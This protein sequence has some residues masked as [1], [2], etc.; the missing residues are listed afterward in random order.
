MN[1]EQNKMGIHHVGED[2]IYYAGDRVITRSSNKAMQQTYKIDSPICNLDIDLKIEPQ[3]AFEGIK[4][5]V[6]LSPEIGRLL[7]AQ[8]IAGIT[9]EAFNKTGFT[10]C[11]VLFIKGKSNM[12]KSHYVPHLTQLY[13]RADGVRADTRFNSTKRFIEDILCENC[14]CTVV[15]DDLHTAESKGIK[16]SNENTAEEIIRRVGDDTGRGHKE[17]NEMVQKKFRGNVIFIG[18]YAIG[19]ESTIPRMLIAELTLRPDGAILDDYQRHKP[20]LVSTFYYYFIQWYVD[21]YNAICNEIDK[22]IS[23]FRKKEGVADIHG[24]LLDTQFYLQTSY[25]IFLEYC[26]D[27]GFIT[28]ED[29]IDEFN[30]FSDQLIE[31]I[32]AQ[33]K[34]LDQDG[35]GPQKRNYLKLIRKL[36]RRGKFRLADNAENFCEDRHDGLIYYECLCIRR[37]SL[38]K[39]LHKI[40]ADIKIDEVISSLIE[41]KALKLVKEKNSVQIVGKRFYAIWLDALK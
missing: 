11:T 6:S 25:M 37:K 10:P 19:R 22:R 18:E 34:K 12:L 26:R 17:G 39:K 1:D 3:A 29:A 30:Y 28:Q 8:A 15:I 13:D 31:L 16:R 4:E 33:Q 35:D 14:E 24:R 21:N 2:V 9:R 40:S 32:L 20:L 38:E 27:S 23:E 41:N 5:L 7:V 36:Y